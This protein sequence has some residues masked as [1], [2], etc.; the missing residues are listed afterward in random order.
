MTDTTTP[1]ATTTIAPLQMVALDEDLLWDA[2][3]RARE[4]FRESKRR[5]SGRD[6]TARMYD[7]ALD[8][9]ERLLE[10]EGVAPW[11]AGEAEAQ[12]WARALRH[13]EGVPYTGLVVAN[14]R[15]ARLHHPSCTSAPHEGHRQTYDDLETALAGEPALTLCGR[16]SRLLGEPQP[17]A[18]ASINQKLA[19]GSSF[20]RFLQGYTARVGGQEVRLWSPNRANPFALVERA[21]IQ[22]FERAVFP[23]AEEVVQMLSLCN[24][25]VPL[26]ARDFA[27][28][29]TLVTTCR[30]AGEILNLRWGEIEPAGDGHYKFRYTYKGGALRWASLRREVWGV[31]VDYLKVSG[32]YP[33][34]SAD[35]VFTALYHE[36]GER[37]GHED[38]AENRPLS[39]SNANAILQKYAARAGVPRGK[40]HL[41]GLRHAGA[42][43]RYREEKERGS[44]DLL[45]MSQF[46]GHANVAVTQVYTQSVL[47]DPA[48]PAGELVV[49]TFMPAAPKRSWLP[50]RPPQGR[51]ER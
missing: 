22:P 46:L 6:N 12:A 37:L 31:I 10:H 25:E 51:Q 34:E 47:E 26:G 15:T 8:D 21:E 33:L 49:D 4:D 7:V 44:F 9:W 16:C 38:L 19:A 23:S 24:R 2:Y 42:R 27:L 48:D 13:G 35:Y 45:E 40:A 11:L 3:G 20:Y 39:N 18:P 43:E 28:L 17:L 5:R 50:R 41:H 29:Y 1:Y 32:R 30:R 36:R 14:T